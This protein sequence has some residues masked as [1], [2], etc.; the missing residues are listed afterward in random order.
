MLDSFTEKELKLVDKIDESRRKRICQGSGAPLQAFEFMQM[1]FKQIRKLVEKFGK[2]KI[3]D[4][5]FNMQNP[6]VL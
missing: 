6:K 4:A 3:G 1:N 2:M 5:N